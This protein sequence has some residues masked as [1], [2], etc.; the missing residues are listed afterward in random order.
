M[1]YTQI[2]SEESIVIGF[3]DKEKILSYV[4]EEEIFEMIFGFKPKEYEYT[5]SPFRE[6]N[7]P[8]CWFERSIYNNKL[9]FVDYADPSFN[10]Q[11][12]FSCVKRFFKLP[13][14]Y[15]TLLFIKK[16]LIDKKGKLEVRE[17]FKEKVEFVPKEK[18][19]VE[20]YIKP[21][22]FIQSDKITWYRYGITRQNLIEDKVIPVTKFT[23]KGTKKGDIT[24]TVYTNCYAYTEFENNR[25]KLYFPYK[26]GKGRFITNCTQ[27]DVGGILKIED[28]PQLLITKAY[29]D[30]RVLKN[31]GVNCVWFQNE[32]MIPDDDLLISFLSNHLDIVVF[33]DND[34]TGIEASLKLV[35]KINSLLPGIARSIMLPQELLLE[36]IKDASD[37]YY[38]R[39]KEQLKEFLLN[40]KIDLC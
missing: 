8:G 30:Y 23:L 26:K 21:R 32:G 3:I 27:N 25:K 17:S 2:D 28:R 35:D 22:N 13:N 16:I 9:L 12:C 10:M 6:D 29:K 4:S 20:I 39:S 5:F 38:L 36:K 15:Q 33:F 31:Q 37:M 7:N 40:N 11:D 1:D 18:R 14:F 19:R 34:K 24:S